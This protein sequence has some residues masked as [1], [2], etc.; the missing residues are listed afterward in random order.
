MSP[1]AGARPCGQHPT[2]RGAPKR[3][4]NQ[5]FNFATGKQCVQQVVNT[6]VLRVI[7]KE[8]D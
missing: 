6:L 5:F 1:T 7:V 8:A 3:P 4:R 2:P